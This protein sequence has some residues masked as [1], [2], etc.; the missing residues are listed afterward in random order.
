[1]NKRNLWVGILVAVAILMFGAGLFL[2]GNEHKA[3]RSHTDFYTEFANMH[4]I[5]KGAKVRVNGMDAGQVDEIVIPASPKDKFRIK[6]TIEER[7]R[8]LVRNN[9]VV[10]VES[11][12]LV[13]DQFLLI[14]SGSESS[15]EAAPGATLPGKEPIE[16][17]KIMEQASGLLN[18]VGGTVTQVDRTITQVNGTITD[19]QGKLD[20]TLIAATRTIN[21]TNGIVTDIRHGKGSAGV[22]LE[23]PET[24][25]NVK[26][27]V[28]NARDATSNLNS[29]SAQ[30]N[31]MVGD[32]QQRQIVAKVDETLN[33]TRSA[34]DQL[35]QA[36]QQVNATL[37]S[38]FAPDQYGLSAGANLQQSL[39]NINQATGNLADDTEALKQEFFFKGFF[40]KRG[41][42]SLDRLPIDSYRNGSLFKK[43][44]E[45]REWLPSSELFEQK[46]APAKP[47]PDQNAPAQAAPNQNNPD[48]NIPDQPGPTEVL[49]AA[50]RAAI[51]QAA[52]Q[53]QD[54]Y[55]SALIVEGYASTGNT[56][57]IL[58]QSRQRA[59]LVRNYLQLR[60]GLASKN[61]GVVGLSTTPPPAT[62]RPTWDGIC[63]VHIASHK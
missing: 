53:I 14:G 22:L 43:H 26:Q 2:I 23:D 30:V 63:L 25:A 28:V 27:T 3:F 29:A 33:N 16:I 10:T 62:G 42:D 54:L 61:I 46:S 39:T 5:A 51:E 36:S 6:M 18:Q 55:T 48:Q 56:G 8:G 7:L 9:S 34:T 15:P 60:F 47:A 17:S 52:S 58:S 12:G 19:V 35:N 11:N 20:G 32:L 59:I 37:K 50:G 49:S 38:A 21:N 45:T 24:A 1:M 31:N 4:G 57:Q 13:G 40:K 41:Y 44:P